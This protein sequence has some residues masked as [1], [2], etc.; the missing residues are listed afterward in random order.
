M[1]RLSYMPG[2][3]RWSGDGSEKELVG[4]LGLGCG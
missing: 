1:Y 4:G 2:G 3:G